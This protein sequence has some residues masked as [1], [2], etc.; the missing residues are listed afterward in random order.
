MPPLDRLYPGA[1]PT[2][3]FSL[4]S[5]ARQASH[6]NF[7]LLGFMASPKF[8]PSRVIPRVAFSKTLEPRQGFEEAQVNG[9]PR[10]ES[11]P[12]RPEDP[13]DKSQARKP[14]KAKRKGLPP[15]RGALSWTPAADEHQGRG[16]WIGG[17][18]VVTKPYVWLELGSAWCLGCFN[19]Q[20]WTGL[21]CQYPAWAHL[22]PGKEAPGRQ[23]EGFTPQGRAETRRV[24]CLGFRVF[25]VVQR[26]SVRWLPGPQ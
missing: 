19:V 11:S 22:G 26:I 5:A 15:K 20:Q 25:F 3:F 14:Q 17:G 21:A 24:S 10:W 2:P 8:P 1:G 13:Q 12:R 18:R 7:L 16:G 4:H 9:W 6:P 23:K